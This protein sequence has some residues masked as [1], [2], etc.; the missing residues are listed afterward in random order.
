MNKRQVKKYRS[1]VVY[2]LVDEYNLL[3]LDEDEYKKAIN[4][5]KNYCIKHCSYKHYKDK[6]KVFKRPFFYSF[7]IGESMKQ[8]FKLTRGK[9]VAP[10][11]IHQSLEQL[12]SLYE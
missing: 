4:D 11:V 2:P 9:A 1:K 7:P 3:T 6:D 5:Y 12:K 8:M 10:V